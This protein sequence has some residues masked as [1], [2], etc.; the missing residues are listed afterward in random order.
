MPDSARSKVSDHYSP[1]QV[2]AIFEIS[3]RNVYYLIRD[4]KIRAHK[5]R[6][7]WWISPEE[8]ERFRIKSER[9]S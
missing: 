3:L 5:V 8:I 6:G 7:L 1:E 4:K 9:A 2:A